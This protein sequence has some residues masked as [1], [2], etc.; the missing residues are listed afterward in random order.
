M[1]YKE[2]K[3]DL[4]SVSDSW[5]LAQCVSADFAMGAGIA[6]QFNKHFNVKEN[7]KSKVFRWFFLWISVRLKALYIR[8]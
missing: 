7:L 4:F 3:R 5:Y 2:E 6:V 8:K 1:F